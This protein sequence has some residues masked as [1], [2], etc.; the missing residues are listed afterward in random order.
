MKAEDDELTKR[1]IIIII[2]FFLI[3]PGLREKKNLKFP[4]FDDAF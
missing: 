2:Y 3:I 4:Q 1:K